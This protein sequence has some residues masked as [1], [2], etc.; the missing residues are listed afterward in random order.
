MDDGDDDDT[1]DDDTDDDT[2]DDHDDD[3]DDT[4][5]DND[6]KNDSYTAAGAAPGASVSCS[7]FQ[8]PVQLIVSGFWLP[9]QSGP[10]SGPERY[11]WKEGIQI[12]NRYGYRWIDYNINLEV[13]CLL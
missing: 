2:D 13:S 1:D 7:G 5:D 3:D 11:K 12:S 8:F 6:H 9:G 4:D 10:A